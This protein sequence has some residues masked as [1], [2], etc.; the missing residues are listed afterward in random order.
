MI[1]KLYE[2][3]KKYIKENY[4]FLITIIVLFAILSIP[5]PYYIYSGGGTIDVANRITIDNKKSKQNFYMCYVEQMRANV[6][7]L[8]LS[9]IIPS[10]D[11]EKI[12]NED[13]NKE[14]ENIINDILL[15][16]SKSNAIINA[17]TKASKNIDITKEKLYITHIYEEADTNLKVGD[18]I[19][20]INGISPKS[21]EDFKNVINNIKVGDTVNIDVVDK[22]KKD[23]KRYAK[24]IE[25]EDERLV[26]VG[27]TTNYEY[28][29]NDDI[30]IEFKG[31]ETGPSGGFMMSLAIYDK[32]L[33]LDLSKDKK[34]CGTGTISIDGQIGEI[35]GVKYK[36][37]GAVED[38]CDI[39]LVPSGDN[40]KEALKEKNNND[41]KINIYQVNNFLDTVEYLKNI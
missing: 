2:A 16:E 13:Y 14:E 38:E 33:D 17:F 35:G 41:Y 12:V 8:G 30:N 25:I 9:F 37:M 18:E 3:I 19:K 15:E 1:T 39:F 23:K 32:L 11:R 6:F 24:I 4:K 29:I 10:I 22:N 34:I 21:L 40:Y 5:V 36:L 20:S 26:G 31:N 28:K 7:S 27:V